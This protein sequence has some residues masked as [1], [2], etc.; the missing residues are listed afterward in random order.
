MILYQNLSVRISKQAKKYKSICINPHFPQNMRLDAEI[1]LWGG[2]RRKEAW[3]ASPGSQNWTGQ[4]QFWFDS[5]PNPSQYC[6]FWLAVG[7]CTN[8]KGKIVPTMAEEEQLF[9]SALLSAWAPMRI[10]VFRSLLLVSGGGKRVAAMAEGE[11]LLSPASSQESA[12]ATREESSSQSSRPAAESCIPLHS[13]YWK[14]FYLM[15]RTI[16]VPL[17]LYHETFSPPY[18]TTICLQ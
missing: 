17:D 5:V 13:R 4:T 16:F 9:G 12:A 7:L 11:Q 1:G 14:N 8:I 18:N 3:F 10:V 2:G 15:E 6:L